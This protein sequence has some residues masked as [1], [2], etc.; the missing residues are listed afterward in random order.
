MPLTGPGASRS[1]RPAVDPVQSAA[2]KDWTRAVL[3]L[4]QETGVLV[5]QLA[6]IEPGCPPVETVI[7]VLHEAGTVSRT[8][9]RPLADVREADVRLAFTTPEEHPH[10]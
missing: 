1:S 5:Q 6:C 10:D 3:G 2:V 8:I 7:A 9:H 4:D